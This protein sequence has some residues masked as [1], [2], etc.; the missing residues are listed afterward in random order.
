ME[1]GRCSISLHKLQVF[2]ELFS[3]KL[4]T[5]RLELML[6]GRGMIGSLLNGIQSI[7]SALSLEELRI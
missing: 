2:V 7:Q 6:C 1:F 5:V 3:L 4:Q